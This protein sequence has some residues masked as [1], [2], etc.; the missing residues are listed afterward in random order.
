LTPGGCERIHCLVK[1]TLFPLLFALFTSVQ[2]QD[3]PPPLKPLPPLPKEESSP[4]A[5]VAPQSVVD[6]AVAA[7]DHLGSEVVQ[8]RYQAA[9][10]SMNPLWKER[11]ASRMGGMKKLD[12]QLSAVA[13]QMVSQGIRILAFKPTGTP[14]AL[15]VGPGKKTE[16]IDGVASEVLIYTKWLVIVPTVKTFQMRLKNEPKPVVIES[17][18]YQVAISDKNKQ[19]WTF[20]DGSGTSL[21]ELRSLF[22]NLPA[23]LKLPPLEKREIR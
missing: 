13:D 22:I 12:E 7:V 11:T 9:V 3:S 5:S 16:V 6:S 15:E 1:F 20:I 4:P 18:G 10:D 21:N 14:Q 23:D 17:I 8:G 19:E 2:A